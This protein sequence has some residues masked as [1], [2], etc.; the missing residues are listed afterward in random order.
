MAL[1]KELKSANAM[2]EKEIQ[3]LRQ[4]LS[5]LETIP[6]GNLHHGSVESVEDKSKSGVDNLRAKSLDGSN[7]DSDSKEIIDES[8]ATAS[9]QTPTGEEIEAAL[10]VE[11][12]IASSIE[13]RF[14]KAVDE[15]LEEN[16][17]FWLRFG[18]SSQ[19]IQKLQMETEDLHSQFSKLSSNS[20]DPSAKPEATPIINRLNKLQTELSEWLEEN[21]S[22]KEELQC[23]NSSLSK[24]Q[25]VITRTSMM[26]YETEQ[27]EFTVYEATKFQ[28]EVLNMQ[29]ENNKVESDLQ[30]GLDHVR[31]LQ[32]EVERILSKLQGDSK[33]TGSRNHPALNPASIPLESFI[34]G[35]KHKK[36]SKFSFMNPALQKQF[37]DLKAQLPK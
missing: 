13:E 6:D 4:K 23:R 8:S 17:Q 5:L 29:Q 12:R 24:M 28:G 36:H 7:S 21:A 31:A 19:Q 16:I 27:V 11:P 22:L 1:V 35:V 18:T 3:S 26:C 34:Y 25:R 20:S 14:R 10:T 33:V 30:T 32:S 9:T 2:K 37:R 15:Q